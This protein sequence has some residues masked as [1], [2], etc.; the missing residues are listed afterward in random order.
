MFRALWQRLVKSGARLSGRR[1][2]GPKPSGRLLR[3]RPSLDFLEDRVTPSTFLVTN[4]LDNNLPGSLRYAISQANQAGKTASI[5]DITSQVTS[6]IILAR[7]ELPVSASMTIRNDTGAPVEIRQ[8]TAGSRV[9]CITS[10]AAR[11]TITGVNSATPITIDGG[12]VTGSNGGG[13]LVEGTTNLNLTTVKL[14]GNSVSMDSA[15]NGGRGGGIYAASGIITLDDGSSVSGNRAPDGIGGGINVETGSVFVQGGSHV[16]ANLARDVGGIRVHGVQQPGTD[17]VRV[18]GLSS[19]NENISTAVVNPL[20]GDFGGGGIAVE[21]DGKVYISSSQVSK[22]KSV[23]M[24]SG[25]IVVGLGDAT[26]T[27][28]SQ[29]M[30][31]TNRGPGG[32]IAANFFGTVTVSGG[33]Q[34]SGNTGA[35]LGGGI[36]NFAGP[37]LGSIQITG[38]SKVDNNTLT[39]EETI[40]Q[41]IA[42]FIK[43][44]LANQKSLGHAGAAAA[45]AAQGAESLLTRPDLLMG[46][47]G[48]GTLAASIDVTGES[49]VNG[50]FCGRRDIVADTTGLGGGVFSVLGRITIDQAAVES[51]KAPFG[52]GGGIYLVAHVL[53]LDNA[54]IMGNI[55]SGDGG[56]ICNGGRLSADDTTIANNMAGGDGGGLFNAKG[57]RAQITDSAFT[58]NSARGTGG[59]VAN[60]ANPHRLKR[61][62]N[63]FTDNTPNDISQL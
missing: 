56:G 11:V 22:N 16:D 43:Y 9:F 18:I 15:A 7:G 46:G 63:V 38:G 51:N 19:V 59:G 4:S 10:G 28:G 44:I 36:V 52:D 62:D 42:V 25:G 3:Y 5:V 45:K 32:G 61:M 54:T 29:I 37:V 48:I 21:S 60:A 33:S 26:V 35:A 49:E 27:D 30:D 39:N 2:Q 40:G 57:A 47:G 58:D 17:A 55:T 8:A 12:S 23:G 13:I 41:A 1:R 6:P 14:I 34:V 31:N 53:T 50:N 24:Y 20:I